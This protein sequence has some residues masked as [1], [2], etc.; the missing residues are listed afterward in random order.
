MMKLAI[1]PPVGWWPVAGLVLSLVFSVAQAGDFARL[2][3]RG[4]LNLRS[5]AA[6]VVDQDSGKVLYGKN[7]A[8]LTPIASLTK[9]MT[10]M[11]VLD[12]DLPMDEWVTIEAGDADYPKRQPSRLKIGLTL[13][14]AELLQLA[15]MASENRAAAALA[16][17]Y[18]GGARACVAAMNRKTYQLGMMD[19]RFVESTG[20]SSDNLS[21][22]R[23]VVKMAVAALHY[24][25]IRALT[26]APSYT[27]VT[28]GGGAIAYRNTNSLIK[29]PAWQI[30]LSK[31]GYISEAGR[32]LVM[33]ARIAAQTV[34]IVLLDSWGKYSRIGDANRIRKWI[35]GASRKSYLG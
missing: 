35:E 7:V 19:S 6:L 28:P 5:A 2:P 13:T 10:A 18:P 8:A 16:R 26:T 22:A 14:R 34:I 17:T 25:Q 23:D 21:T 32:C 12:A 33:Q 1:W 15:L 29:N 24:P 31:T 11:V 20:L 30:G 4:A 3:E 9:L 27:V